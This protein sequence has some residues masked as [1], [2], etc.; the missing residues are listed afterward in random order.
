MGKSSSKPK[1]RTTQSMD[2]HDFSSSPKTS[3]KLY[4]EIHNMTEF[5]F[6]NSIIDQKNNA[7][8]KLM[9]SP[10]V[11]MT[12][13]KSR[14]N[15]PPG[16]MDPSLE[17][18]IDFNKDKLELLEMTRDHLKKNLIT[19]K[20]SSLDRVKSS[21]NSITDEYMKNVRKHLD[22]NLDQNFEQEMISPR[23]FLQKGAPLA[24]DSSSNDQLLF[25]LEES[26]AKR[27]AP[28]THE[29][30]LRLYKEN[31]RQIKSSTSSHPNFENFKNKESD[32]LPRQKSVKGQR[33]SNTVNQQENK[34]DVA[35]NPKRR[36]KKLETQTY[37]DVE[38]MKKFTSNIKN[39]LGNKSFNIIFQKIS[40]SNLLYY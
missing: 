7:Q 36:I 19:K 20:A 24:Y 26:E 31:R 35:E 12:L 21:K 25:N 38:K 15:I 28:I 17:S 22:W 1:P 39:L 18:R 16:A 32:S 9:K 29:E 40:F 4:S 10:L 14:H 8:S 33:P 2:S 6:R 30:L 3:E 5:H 11:R 13:R 37:A 27:P 34:V 23:L